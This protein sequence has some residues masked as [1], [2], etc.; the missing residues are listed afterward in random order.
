M[1]ACEPRQNQDLSDAIKN[2]TQLNGDEDG[3]EG[4][5]EDAADASQQDTTGHALEGEHE[6]QENYG[7]DPMNNGYSNMNLQVSGD[8]NQMQMMMAMQNGMGNNGFGGFPMMG[9]LRLSLPSSHF[10]AN[11]R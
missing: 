8:F 4:P 5:G 6:D 10:P 2:T 9:K 11:T 7:S 1:E 3:R